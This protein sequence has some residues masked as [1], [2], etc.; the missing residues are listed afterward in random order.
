MGK[1][2]GAVPMIDP[3]SGMNI[4]D[5]HLFPEQADQTTGLGSWASRGDQVQPQGLVREINCPSC[6]G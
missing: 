6:S 4:I 5:F 1:Q 2:S 3:P